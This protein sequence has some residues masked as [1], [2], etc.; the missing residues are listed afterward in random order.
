M[1][2]GRFRWTKLCYTLW[3]SLTISLP[4]GIIIMTSFSNLFQFTQYN[5]IIQLYKTNTK[6]DDRKVLVDKIMPYIMDV[7]NS[8]TPVRHDNYDVLRKSRPVCL[9][10]FG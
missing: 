1:M 2:T 5:T 6:T 4:E 9:K 7:L 3:T 10:E 8:F